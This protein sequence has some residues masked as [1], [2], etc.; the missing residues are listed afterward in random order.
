STTRKSNERFEDRTNGVPGLS[1]KVT[2]DVPAG[3]HSLSVSLAQPAGA[4]ACARFSIPGAERAE[5]YVS[6]TPLDAGE[7]YVAVAGEKQITYYG[8]DASR[9]VT[10][11][12][13]GPARLRIL[14]RLNFDFSLHGERRYTLDI[15]QDGKPFRQDPLITTRSTSVPYTNHPTV[16]PGKDK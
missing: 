6:I 16:I 10:V 12:V 1:R 11:R 13:V 5:P 7:T 9:A 8:A 2:I 3:R 15:T 4:S 14:S